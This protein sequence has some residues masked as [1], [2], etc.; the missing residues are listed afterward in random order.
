MSGSIIVVAGLLAAGAPGPRPGAPE[1]DRGAELTLRGEVVET[2]ESQVATDHPGLHL[3][4]KSETE[5]VEV[6]TCPVHFLE[7]LAFPIEVGDT[8]TVTGSRR[9]GTNVVVARKLT[10]GQLSLIV[11]DETGAPNWLPRR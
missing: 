6:H 4:L 9:K 1:Y 7:E 3:V 2:H 10:K 11:R 5:T 8:L